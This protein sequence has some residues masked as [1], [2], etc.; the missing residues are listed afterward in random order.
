MSN[1]V[2]LV[3]VEAEA[4]DETV[5]QILRTFSLGGSFAPAA[6]PVIDAPDLPTPKALPLVAPAPAAPNPPIFKFKK[7]GRPQKVAAPKP[8]GP[9]P[10]TSNGDG[11]SRG[12]IIAALAKRPMTSGEVIKETKLPSTVV[13]SMLNILRSEGTVE[14]REGETQF[15]V[16]HLVKK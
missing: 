15:K 6:D 5:Q 1:K 3:C 10:A 9:A 8:K 4:S 7:R 14:S 2:R 16:Q 12:V 11:K 13:Y